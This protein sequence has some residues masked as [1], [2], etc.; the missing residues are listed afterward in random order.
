M[1]DCDK[2]RPGA[3]FPIKKERM[4]S[5][6]NK[7][8]YR[9]KEAD[10]NDDALGQRHAAEVLCSASVLRQCQTALEITE[11]TVLLYDAEADAYRQ[12]LLLD[13]PIAGRLTRCLS[14]KAD[15][16]DGFMQRQDI[17]RIRALAKMAAEG[18]KQRE[19]IAVQLQMDG[20]NSGWHLFC[21]T[22]AED[23]AAS[24]CA[25]ITVRRSTGKWN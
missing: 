1:T 7:E 24:H 22:R 14:E 9:S 4:L 21:I 8:V 13:S 11:T 18:K 12:A 19:T 25:L 10:R 2:G 15:C 17:E 23:S 3:Y 20:G 6:V 5:T 16:A